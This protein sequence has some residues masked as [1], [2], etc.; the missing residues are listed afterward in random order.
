MIG[1][2]ATVTEMQN[3]FG[4][5]LDLVMKGHEVIVTK[6]GKEVGRFI[7]KDASPLTDSLRGILRGHWDLDEARDEG[8]RK[9]YEIAD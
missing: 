2:T 1:A 3:D 4:R 5:Y 6:T 9:K 8:L 7:P